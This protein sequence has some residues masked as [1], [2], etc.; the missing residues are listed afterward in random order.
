MSLALAEKLI[1]PRSS[2]WQAHQLESSLKGRSLF[3]YLI[4]INWPCLILQVDSLKTH[5]HILYKVEKSSKVFSKTTFQC[6]IEIRSS[7]VSVV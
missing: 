2:S 3:Q 4:D 1:R 7:S 6:W 5:T